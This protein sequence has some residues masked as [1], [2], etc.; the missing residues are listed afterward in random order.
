[1]STDSNQLSISDLIEKLS[2]AAMFLRHYNSGPKEQAEFEAARQTLLE[3][4]EGDLKEARLQSSASLLRHQLDV[5]QIAWA[6]PSTQASE[7]ADVIERLCN[8]LENYRNT[9][10]WGDDDEEML[11]EARQVVAG[12]REVPEQAPPEQG[13]WRTGSPEWTDDDSVRVIAVT[14]NDE[15]AGVQFHDI[16][17]SDFYRQDEDGGVVGTEVTQRCT[18][19]LYRDELWLLGAAALPQTQHPD[20]LAIDR[21]AT[22]LKTKMAEGRAKGRQGWETCPPAELSNMLRNHVE[23]GDPRDVALF[24]MMLWHQAAAIA[25]PSPSKRVY[26]VATGETCRGLETYTR[27]ETAVPLADQE[28]L[29][30]AVPSVPSWAQI[31]S[32]QIPS[33]PRETLVRFA[34]AANNEM[35][36]LCA[37]IREFND[38]QASK[39]Q[40]TDDTMRAIRTRALDEFGTGQAQ[41]E[42]WEQILMR[43]TARTIQAVAKGGA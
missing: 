5:A 34:R 19:W 13:L 16:R 15:F 36:R 29:L 28:M 24:C 41:G 35:I 9:T 30:A 38:G 43:E 37:W 23:K 18:Q 39:I 4:F 7:A 22:A 14:A 17:A 25:V 26:L 32:E 31:S 8:G 42:L 1:M 3:K 40:L 20:D 33:W 11:V 12:L 6:G 10:P 21:F 27:H 2:D